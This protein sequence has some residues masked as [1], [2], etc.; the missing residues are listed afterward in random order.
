MLPWKDMSLPVNQRLIRIVFL[1]PDQHRE[2]IVIVTC[3][4]I[5]DRHWRIKSFKGFLQHRDHIAEGVGKQIIVEG[6]DFRA[7][8]RV[9]IHAGITAAEDER[10]GGR[11]TFIVWFSNIFRQIIKQRK[12]IS[13]RRKSK[14]RKNQKE[15]EETLHNRCKSPFQLLYAYLAINQGILLKVE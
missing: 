7:A 2:I 10:A 12:R 4:V 3:D 5:G 11:I 15:Q 8:F 13:Q 9:F 6:I 1:C 14:Q